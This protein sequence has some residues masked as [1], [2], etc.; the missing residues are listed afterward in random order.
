MTYLWIYLVAALVV[1]HIWAAESVSPYNKSE[2]AIQ[3]IVFIL[4]G[5]FFPVFLLFKLAYWILDLVTIEN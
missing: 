3:A 1:S 4:I 2:Q 5:L